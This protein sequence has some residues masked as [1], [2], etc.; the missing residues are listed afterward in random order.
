VVKVRGRIRA[1][2]RPAIRTDRQKRLALARVKVWFAA[3]INERVLHEDAVLLVPLDVIEID[4]QGYM[5]LA[6][7]ANPRD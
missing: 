5:L 6:A 3:A 4:A 2:Q 7:R 1:Q